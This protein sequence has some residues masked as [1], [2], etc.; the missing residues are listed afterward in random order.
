MR[1]KRSSTAAANSSTAAPSATS[2]VGCGT[3]APAASHSP[4]TAASGSAERAQSASEPP[5]RAIR[6]AA[7]RPIP[8]EA[9]VTTTTACSSGRGTSRLLAEA[10]FLG[11]VVG[12]LEEVG[13]RQRREQR[14]DEAGHP[15]GEQEPDREGGDHPEPEAEGAD[16]ELAD[17]L[18]YPGPARTLLQLGRPAL[19]FELGERRPQRARHLVLGE[20]AAE[21]VGGGAEQ[22]QLR[23]GHPLRQLPPLPLRQRQR[24][25]DQE[26]ERA[27]EAEVGEKG[28]A[29]LRIGVAGDG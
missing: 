21:F 24:R 18:P 13:D 6:S 15:R 27:H 12:D 28:R 10:F 8:L 19:A 29:L 14:G 20:E 23:R 17:R 26:A 3:A 11:G 16:Q 5:R 4:A 9:P 1:P 22:Q 2:S 7:A 25:R